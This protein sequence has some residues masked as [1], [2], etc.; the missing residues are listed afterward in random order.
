MAIVAAAQCGV[1][2]ER[3]RRVWPRRGRYN[4]RRM[5][6][7]SNSSPVPA[8]LASTDSDQAA[9]AR[10]EGTV[11]GDRLSSATEPPGARPPIPPPTRYIA[12]CL[13]G[14]IWVVPF[15]AVTWPAVWPPEN[16]DPLLTLFVLVSLFM[17][18][19]IP[20]VSDP[21]S[22]SL[23]TDR[24]VLQRVVPI[25]SFI[26][27]FLGGMDVARLH[28]SDVVPTAVRVGALVVLI[29]AYSLRIWAVYVNTFFS[30]P[31]TIQSERGHRVIDSGPY[32]WIRHP[33][34][35]SAI[36]LLLMGPVVV[37]SLLALIPAGVAAGAVVRRCHTEDR[38]LLENLSGYAAYAERVRRRMIPGL[39]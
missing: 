18:S 19:A 1:D 28:W 29:A 34:N 33:G 27:L 39:Y 8:D 21:V 31:V 36:V 22:Y 17:S 3:P 26:G 2:A 10:G 12:A 24:D 11:P 20:A 25:A 4:R 13:S 30:G 37:N 38:F 23:R 6:Q 15:V 5:N 16:Y 35:L 7:P 32:R 9:R 14:L